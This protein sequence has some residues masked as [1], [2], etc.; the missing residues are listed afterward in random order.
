MKNR[1][2]ILVLFAVT[3]L[4]GGVIGFGFDVL[5]KYPEYDI[6]LQALSG[7]IGVALGYYFTVALNPVRTKNDLTFTAFSS[8]VISG[9][10]VAVRKFVQFFID[11]YTGSN[12]L[13][14]EMVEDEHWLYRVFGF[15]MSPEAQRPLLDTDEDFAISILFSLLS[16][17]VLYLYMRLKN[18]ALFVREAVKEKFTFRSIP[19]RIKERISLEIEKVRN[20]C[21]I[22]DIL[23]WWCTRAV[24]VYA[25]IVMENRAEAT[26]LLANL[27]GT[28]AITLVHFIL[29][30]NSVLTKVS[31]KAQSLIT[32]IVFLGSWCGNFVGVYYITP[33][34]DLF[35]HLISGYLCVM[36]G[37]YVALTLFK[38]ENKRKALLISVF[39]L[40]FSFFIMPFWEVSEFI[41]DFIWGTSNQ[42]FY[43]GPTD[44]S[45]FFK[46]FGHGVGNTKLYYLFDTFYDMLLAVVSTVGTFIVLCAGLVSGF[47]RNKNSGAAELQEEKVPVHS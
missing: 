34:F 35:L 46:V 11:F 21:S 19:C 28:F 47:K 44:D 8:L 31:Y 26:L 30:K 10:I 15:G 23:L 38:P 3:A 43:W 17:G 9:T 40:C 45:F 14:C 16:T 39:A 42:G 6:F 1:Y 22:W 29:P 4:F 12:L 5:E 32:I 41:G 37:Y 36:G 18:K 25:F 7:I 20:D 13:H 33:R 24:M 2:K 27:V